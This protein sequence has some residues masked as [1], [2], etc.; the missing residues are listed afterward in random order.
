M[1]GVLQWLPLLLP[2][3][4]ARPAALLADAA[5]VQKASALYA[6]LRYDEAEAAFTN[7]LEAGD[8]GPAGLVEIHRFLGILA[9]TRNQ[10]EEAEAH[11]TRMLLIGGEASMPADVSPKIQRPYEA[12]M[13]RLASIERFE[14]EH[15]P[16]ALS[17]ASP[18]VLQ[19]RWRPDGLG[20]VKDLALA[21]RPRRELSY[22]VIARIDPGPQSFELPE[23]VAA[24][25]EYYLVLRDVYGNTV[26]N[27]GTPEKPLLTGAEE[28]G[29]AA[30]G[31]AL[32]RPWYQQPSVWVAG[33]LL[34]VTALS[35]G[36]IAF[37]F[38]WATPPPPDFDT[39]AIEVGS[40]R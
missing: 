24:P 36:V 22:M 3:L 11:F 30:G 7:A 32:E 21:Y 38:W 39:I 15:Q 33:G 2:A 4:L 12:A 9:A 29:A 34:A 6:D 20:M 25:V 37:G 5:A 17:T 8:N 13:A 23:E 28:A 19:V 35:V 1:R 10:E 26:F 16:V 18:Q 40:A 14:L 31:G 27:V